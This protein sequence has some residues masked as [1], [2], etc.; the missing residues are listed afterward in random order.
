LNLL[1]GNPIEAELYFN[2]RDFRRG[3]TRRYPPKARYA[4]C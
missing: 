2:P 1:G 4:R 3:G